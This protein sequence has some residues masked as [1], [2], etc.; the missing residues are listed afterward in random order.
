MARPF[1]PVFFDNETMGLWDY[2]KFFL[3]VPFSHCPIIPPSHRPLIPPVPSSHPSPHPILPP[4]HP[5]AVPSS[6]RPIIPS[7]HHPIVPSSHHPIIPLS[8][9]PIVASFPHF[10]PFFYHFCFANYLVFRNFVA[11]CVFECR[12]LHYCYRSYRPIT[13]KRIC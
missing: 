2:E 10:S 12:R 9:H 1:S 5:P 13:I 11:Y 7:P 3:I 8:H 6:H 4:S